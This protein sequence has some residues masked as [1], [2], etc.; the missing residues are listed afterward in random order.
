MLVEWPV[1]L[2]VGEWTQVVGNPCSEDAE[3]KLAA[4]NCLFE[5]L[6][7]RDRI[8]SLQRLLSQKKKE[9]LSEWV[10]SSFTG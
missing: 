10:K 3:A 8:D 7:G 5:K 2:L 1:S 4:S 9:D 6:V